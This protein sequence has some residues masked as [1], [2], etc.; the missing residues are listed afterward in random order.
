MPTVRR[1]ER[2]QTIGGPL[3]GMRRAAATALSEGAG[4]EEARADKFRSMAHTLGIAS[5]IGIAEYGRLVEEEK[6]AADQTAL[7]E[8]S[9]KLAA[10]RS[11][12]LYD[13]NTG[14]LAKRGKDALGAPE[15]VQEGFEK[16]TGDIEAGLSTDKQRAAWA[17][18]KS[19]EGQQLDLQVR[20]HTFE[21]VQTYRA[22]ELKAHVENSMNAAIQNAS[23]P[24]LVAVEL[25]KAVGALKANAPSLGVGPEELDAQVRGVTSN[26]HLG[27]ISQLLAQ[28]KDQQ[29]GAYFAATKDQISGDKLDEV[30][31]ALEEGSTR[32]E[33]QRQADVLG[34]KGTLQ[35][36]L[37]AAAKIDNPK[38]RDAVEDRLRRKE[39]D[40]RLE[41]N[42]RDQATQLTAYDIL[43]RTADTTKIPPMMW[44]SFDGGTRAAMR[45]YAKI[46]AKGEEPETDWQTFYSLVED[47]QT[48][49]NRFMGVNLLSYKAK[50]GDTEFKQLMGWRDAIRDGNRKLVDKEI[51]PL[52]ER[53]AALSDV[54]RMHGF[55]PTPKEGSDDAQQVARIRRLLDQKVEVLQ[56]GGKKASNEEIRAE[57]MDLMA[58]EVTVPGRLYGTNQKRLVDVTAGDIPATDRTQIEESLRRR[59]MPV[60]DETILDVYLEHQLR[61]S[62]SGR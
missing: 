19:Q 54:L 55:D 2:Q 16:I 41:E 51:A 52:Q 34:A 61:R 50:L 49:P 31:R 23:D 18:L 59:N 32:G 58:R 1:Y 21:Q 33:A 22:G 40:R 29:A 47:A 39:Q 45:S 10:W 35:E 24:K 11:T 5:R 8:A 30:Q 3:Q 53:S 48:N 15:E 7:L 17:R 44:S 12:T 46:R 25:Q 56:A 60:S 37:D 26:V 28:E 36:Q 27:V 57:A 4:V 20:R 9:N 42:R 13:P 43:D 6:D 62:R 38:V 14:V